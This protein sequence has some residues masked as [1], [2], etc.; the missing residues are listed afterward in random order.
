M[1]HKSQPFLIRW[2]FDPRA[3]M[4]AAD[5]VFLSADMLKRCLPEENNVQDAGNAV[6]L[7]REFLKDNDI[8]M[9]EALQTTSTGKQTY[10]IIN[11]PSR[12][13]A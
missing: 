8:V 10:R 12:F 6:S 5:N 11:K 4:D 9:S 1:Q 7:I 3:L 13:D 2:W